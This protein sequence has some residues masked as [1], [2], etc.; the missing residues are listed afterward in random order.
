MRVTFLTLLL[1]TMLATPVQ[2]DGGRIAWTGERSGRRA[3]IVV[4]PV[5]PRVGGV[6]LDW[7]GPS[8]GE[9]SVRAEHET[10]LLIEAPLVRQNGEWHAI[11][12]MFAEGRWTVRLDPDGVGGEDPIEIPIEIGPAIPPWQTQW[13][14]VLAWV[15]MVA[16]GM[17]V[18]MRRRILPRDS[19]EDPR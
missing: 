14:W 7:I 2:G 6:Q 15:P 13:P 9:G 5:A 19:Q 4:A 11:L 3:A 1:V 18:A 16:V 10:G 8:D 12:E 17:F